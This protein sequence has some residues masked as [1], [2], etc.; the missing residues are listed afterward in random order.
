MIKE[1][2]IGGTFKCP[3]CNKD[4]LITSTGAQH[5][6]NNHFIDIPLVEISE[7]KKWEKEFNKKF[8]SKLLYGK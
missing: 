1:D 4:I 2:L 7:F 6:G 3:W 5:F 8:Y